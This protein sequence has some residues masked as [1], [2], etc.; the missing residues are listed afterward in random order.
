LVTL[1]DQVF[2]GHCFRT[3][4]GDNGKPG[5]QA[6]PQCVQSLNARY[7]RSWTQASRRRFNSVGLR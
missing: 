1:A 5:F 6:R 3:W 7:R 2:L 4:F